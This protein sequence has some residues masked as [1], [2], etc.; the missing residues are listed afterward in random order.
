MTD[1]L[2]FEKP[3][4]TFHVQVRNSHPD[5]SGHVDERWITVRLQEFGRL[6]ERL[7]L[8]EAYQVTLT[9]AEELPG[10]ETRV[11]M[12]NAPDGKMVCVVFT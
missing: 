3:P 11:V 9:T 8:A 6:A 1:E 7:T 2:W 4:R 10:W 12:N 5:P